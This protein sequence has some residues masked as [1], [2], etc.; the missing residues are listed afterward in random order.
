MAALECGRGGPQRRARLVGMAGIAVGRS[1]RLATA[2]LAIRQTVTATGTIEPAEQANLTSGSMDR[3]PRYR[4][5]WESRCSPERRWRRWTRRRCRA[6]SPKR[7]RRWHRRWPRSLLSAAGAS[8]AQVNADNAALASANAELAEAQ[9]NLSKATLTAPFAGTVA[10]VTLTVGQQ[11]SGASSA[12]SGASSAGS[13]D[14]SGSGGTTGPV[15]GRIRCVER[16]NRELDL[17]VE[18]SGGGDQHR[19]L[20]RQR[21]R[22]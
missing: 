6:S 1:P 13:G 4:R 17:S 9:Q 8:A 21:Q 5:R 14:G 3:S 11:I 19:Q 2:G 15:R 16:G 20:R 10:A 12:G 7:T 18:C 22:R